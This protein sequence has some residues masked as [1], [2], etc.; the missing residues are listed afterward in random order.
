[1]SLRKLFIAVLALWILLAPLAAGAQQPAKVPR[2]GYLSGNP[3]RLTDVFQQRLGELGYVEGRNVIIEYRWVGVQFERLPELAAELVR[4]KVDVLVAV[5]PPAVWAAKNATSTIPIVMV[6]VDDPVKSGLVPSLARPGGNITGLTWETDVEAISGKTLRLLKE[7]VPKSARVAILWNLDNQA[8]PPYVKMFQKV[9]PQLGMTLHALGVRKPEEFG[10]AFRQMI[11]ERADAL[12][13]FADP[14]TVPRRK[15]LIELPGRY[16]LPTMYGLK[17]FV[18]DGGLM[19]YGPSA[20]EMWRRAGDY[21]AKIL[22]GAKPADLPVEQPT[23]FELVI[24]LKTA[25]ALGLTIPQSILLRADQVI[26]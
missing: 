20:E 19:S 17:I 1:M 2:V 5:G 3:G 11:K 18:A 7:V 24:N 9:G 23:R 14:L 6:A 26:R 12:F 22:K 21:V 15:Q 4:L 25:K 8:H 10:G 13:V 16:R